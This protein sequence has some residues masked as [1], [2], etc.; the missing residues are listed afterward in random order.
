MSPRIRYGFLVDLRRC[1][2][3]HTCSVVCKSEN[4]VNLGVWRTW[5]KQIEKGHT[6]NVKKS[7]LPTLCNNCENPICVTVCPVQA[8]KIRPD[9]IVTYDPHRCVGCR[10]CMASCPYEVRYINPV[11]R[12]VEKCHW[13]LHRVERGLEPACVE[14]CPSS[15]RIFGNLA[16]PES[17]ISK[18]IH[19]HP[20]QVLLPEMGTRPQ[21]Y[22][23]DLDHDVVEKKAKPVKRWMGKRR[24]GF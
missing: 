22:Y 7:F 24:Y 13:C 4:A 21:V 10:Y 8:N 15:A 6:P 14:A 5:V 1:M 20:V 16:D 11:K 18:L 3:C 19:E 2:G 12:F 23:I 9:G 17:Q